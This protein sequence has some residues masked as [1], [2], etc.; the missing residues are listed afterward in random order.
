MTAELLQAEYDPGVIVLSVLI[1]VFSSYAALDLARRVHARERRA[2]AAW[3]IGGAFVMGS[4]IWSMHFVGMLAFELP[5]DIRYSLPMTLLSWAIAVAVS[6]LALALAARERLDGPTLAAGAGLMG[7]GICAMHYT[8][9]AAIEIAPGIAWHAGWIA[10]S[11]AIACAASAVALLLFFGMRRLEGARAQFV[12]AGAALVMG[13]AISGMHY[14]GMAAAGFPA[15]A[16]CL[17]RDGLGGHGLVSLVVTATVLLLSI[18]VLVSTLD[19]RLQAQATGLADSLRQAND[20]LQEANGEL[21]RLAFVD[22]LT[23]VPNRTLFG[24]RLAHAVARV[25]RALEEPGRR[26][27]ERLGLLFIDLDGFKAVND[28]EGHAAGD[29]LLREVAQ[30]LQGV[31]RGA[32]TLARLGGD[33]F[34]LLL[35]GIAGA[36]D[37]VAVA[38]RV[39]AVLREPFELPQRRVT[40][41][42]SIGIVLY[43]DHGHRDRLTGAADAAMY[44]AKNAGGDGYAVFEP[45]MQEG[46]AQQLD[47]Q[48]ALREAL[49]AGGL[50]LHYQPKVDA[51]SGATT[52]AEALLRWQHPARGLIGPGIF[53]PVAERFGLILRIGEWVIE[54]ACRQ[55]AA[56]SAEGRTL[57]LSINLSAYQLRQPDLAERLRAAL[58]RHGVEPGRLVCEITET[59]AMEDTPTTQRVIEQLSALGVKLSVDDFGT[60]YSSLA[61]LRQLRPHELKIDRS[62]V[63]DVAANADARAVVD[64]IVRLAHAL[65][66]RVVA[67]G[68][69][70]AVQHEVLVALGCDELQ[71]FHFGR[72]VPAE[73]LAWDA[74]VAA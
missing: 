32:D 11:V 62:F 63:L 37:A 24:D 33:E 39:L 21:R 23:G 6:A 64:A 57:G 59:A 54:E 20:Q 15:G 31:A 10:A 19:A 9:M 61:A 7:A 22:P 43:P 58:R 29:G 45:R 1:A 69:E 16:V 67:E 30:R 28:G 41:S 60:G 35:E 14:S 40:L 51:H 48:Q 50:R 27:A 26:E 70:T 34:V 71:G 68:V 53:I 74:S 73:A 56:W 36:P 12:Q 5:I 49:E 46:P 8:G 2:A 52:G 44:S 3:T 4:G 13:A 55:L 47:L 66:L 17:T 18:G 72:P 65:G 42:C 25:D 38:E